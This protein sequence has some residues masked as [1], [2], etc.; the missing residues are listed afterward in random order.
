M[1][2]ALG[3]LRLRPITAEDRPFL[4]AL[5]RSVRWEELAPTGWPDEAK[6][7]FLASQF[8][9]QHR[10]F[11]AYYPAEGLELVEQDG[12]PIGRLYVDRTPRNTYLVDIALLPQWRGRGVGT[13]LIRALQDDVRMRGGE[14]TLNVDR[15]NPDAERLYRRLG[16]VETPPD[17][18]YPGVSIDMRWTPPQPDVAQP[19]TAS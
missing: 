19:N 4:E 1:A 10:Q 11:T 18:P 7:A 6:L 2:I 17:V 16:F 8:D 5:Y 14:L 12:E 13:R 9:L 15:T 3:A